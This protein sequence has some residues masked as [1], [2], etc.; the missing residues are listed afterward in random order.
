MVSSH[1]RLGA[2]CAGRSVRRSRPGR[3]RAPGSRPP[4]LAAVDV[5]GVVAGRH[6]DGPPEVGAVVG[7][8]PSP[9]SATAPPPVPVAHAEGPSGARRAAGAGRSPRRAGP[10]A[11]CDGRRV[12]RPPRA[13]RRAERPGVS[14]RWTSTIRPARTAPQ[15]LDHGVSVAGA[16]GLGEGPD[17]VP[18][19]GV[20]SRRDGALG[21]PETPDEVP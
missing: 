19:A 14:G 6:Q 1:Q 20:R 13:A 15:Y 8:S 9:L 7:G 3:G 11:A 17:V 4:G 5:E 12:R 21:P 18:V 16:D 10:G 2:S